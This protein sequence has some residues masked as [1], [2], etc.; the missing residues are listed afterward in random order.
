MMAVC[1]KAAVKEE[2]KAEPAKPESANNE[3]EWERRGRRVPKMQ[4]NDQE[5]NGIGDAKNNDECRGLKYTEKILLRICF[6]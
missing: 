1:Q 5:A 6:E 3:V 2:S 4:D